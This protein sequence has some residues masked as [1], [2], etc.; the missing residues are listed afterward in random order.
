MSRTL[1]LLGSDPLD[2][3]DKP[4]PSIPPLDVDQWLAASI[5]Q[6][7]IRR[8]LPD[9]AERAAVTLSRHRGPRV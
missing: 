2:L 5:L 6:K 3:G 7:A 1:P 8:G 4:L 9:L